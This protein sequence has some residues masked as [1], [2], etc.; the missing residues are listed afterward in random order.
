MASLLDWHIPFMN[1]IG[2]PGIIKLVP[3]IHEWHMPVGNAITYKLVIST[4]TTQN[5][6]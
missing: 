6:R 5:P 4:I 2:Q 1:L 3:P